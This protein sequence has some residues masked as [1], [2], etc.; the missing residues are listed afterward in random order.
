M[1]RDQRRLLLSRT[2]FFPGGGGQ[3]H[4]TGTI[5]ARGRQ[6]DVIR[7][8]RDAGGIWHWIDGDLELPVAGATVEGTLDWS[9]RHLVMRTHT[10]LHILCGVIWEEFKIPV[11]G[12]NMDVGT[13]RLDFP[14]EHMSTELG[15]RVE[16][17]INEEIDA[18]R[19]IAVE[20][21][22]RELA[23][24]DPA[25]IRTAAN[26]IPREIDPLRIINIVGLDKQADGGTHVRVDR[27]GRPGQS[28]RHGVQ[29]QRQ[30]ADPDRGRG[31]LTMSRCPEANQHPTR[32]RSCPPVARRPTRRSIPT[33]HLVTPT[34]TP[35]PTPRTREARSDQAEV[36]QEMAG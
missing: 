31:R 35:I 13:G 19:E 4:D 10:A 22:G 11:T 24:A 20:F 28:H 27:R 16:A 30:Q 18:A 12:G 8:K 33:C 7:V 3:P 1:D 14:F 29:G 9:R 36:D 21:L 34:R 23:D 26:L 25:L 6:A 17:R 32:G 2:A 5:S 15:E